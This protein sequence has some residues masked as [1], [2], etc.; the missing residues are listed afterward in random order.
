MSCGDGAYVAFVT[1]AV[2]TVTCVKLGRV[3]S[4]VWATNVFDMRLVFSYYWMFTQYYGTPHMKHLLYGRI[5]YFNIH[6]Q[7]Q[8]P[9]K[10][11][12]QF[13]LTNCAMLLPVC[14]I[15]IFKIG[16]ISVMLISLE[17]NGKHFMRS[18]SGTKQIGSFW[19]SVCHRGIIT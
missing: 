8:N 9:F 10:P 19:Q 15:N 14:I 3:L 13:I 6:R 5:S 17:T 7:Y 11:N 12:I 18:Q 2:K 4:P 16:F 1:V